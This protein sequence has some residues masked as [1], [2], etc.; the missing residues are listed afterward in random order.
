[1]KRRAIRLNRFLMLFSLASVLLLIVLTGYVLYGKTERYIEEKTDLMQT[2]KGSQTAADVRKQFED[3]YQTMDRLRNSSKLIGTLERLQ[4]PDVASYEKVVLS[5]NVESSLFNLNKGNELIGSITIWTRDSQYSSNNQYSPFYF[6]GNRMSLDSIGHEIGFVPANRTYAALALTSSDVQDDA[7]RRLLDEWNRSSYFICPVV[8]SGG[9]LGILKIDI[10]AGAFNHVLSY[11]E[12]LAILDAKDQVLFSGS[13]VAPELNELLQ[14][15]AG[16]PQPNG[17]Y[18]LSGKTYVFRDIGFHGI[19]IAVAEAA[20]GFHQEQLRTLGVYTM[21]ILGGSA[22]L[23]FFLS[24]WIGRKILVPLHSLIGW[25]GRKYTPEAPGKP[26]FDE[27]VAAH[28]RVTMRDRFF[29]YFLLTIL[30]PIGLFVTIF[31]VNSSR[32]IAR[33]LEETFHVLFDKTAQRVELFAGQKET[34]LTRLGYD[35]FVASYVSEP[36][37]KRKGEMDQ[38]IF[39]SSFPTLSED[40]IGVY[41]LDN[42]LIYS[43]RYKHAAKI[44]P[45]F[46]EQMR[47]S[48][49]NI[50]YWLPPADTASSTI[51]LAIG[52]VDINRYSRPVGYLKTDINGVFLTNLYADL[53]GSG[54][55]AFIVDDQGRILSQPDAEKVGQLA[56]LPFAPGGMT[57]DSFRTGSAIYFAEKI[58]SLPWY[59]IARYD[60]SAIQDQVLRL[61]Y[62]DVYLLLILF[63]LI[64][65]FSYLMSQYLVRPL[66]SLQNQYGRKE[67]DSLALLASEQPYAI[68]EVEQLRLSFN[69]MLER[70]D[71]L[72]ADTLAA[73]EERLTLEFEKKELHLEALQAQINPH[74]LYNTLE[75]IMYMV[76]E[77][78]RYLAAD[79]IGL[80]SR[81][82]RYAMGKDSP[83]TTLREEV[84]N[85]QSYL[86]IMSYR[87]SERVRCEWRVDED[88]ADCTINKMILQPI[89]ENAIKHSLLAPDSR[90]NLSV[91]GARSGED[92]EL[93]ITDNGPGIGRKTL[94]D[95]RRN[96]DRRDRRNIGLYNVNSRIK[97]HFG[98]RYGLSVDS[99]GTGTT[100]AIRLPYRR[101]DSVEAYP[102]R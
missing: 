91:R 19:R 36:S 18:P 37:D 14:K 81:M 47:A 68:D 52:I 12:S 39:D 93:T 61:F 13:D 32:I 65:I 31:Y 3:I 101:S 55:D 7:F 102:N 80:L 60:A 97:L 64:L 70:I 88:I 57:A 66:A 69:R 62:D 83:L 23:A 48:R 54:S 10:H 75:H 30:L 92:I 5:E 59:L 8:G 56:E 15:N 11:G 94:D 78:E 33:E 79:M 63:L 84:A 17:G 67:T 100:V 73:G 58:G 34:A 40:A 86:K 35:A 95:I 82:F 46:F 28:R 44:E 43:N 9:T 4:R 24:H 87:Y 38:L 25:I 85:A 27:R 29:V 41:D 50:F 96:L 76:E 16:K 90:V 22:L 45:S 53:K 72:V 2:M 21:L 99:E 1:M 42:R 77:G 26:A 74:F 51:S 98:N 89:I 71:G 20:S 49:K 6:E